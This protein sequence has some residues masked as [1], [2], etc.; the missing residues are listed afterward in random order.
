MLLTAHFGM[1]SRP[2]SGTNSPFHL[3]SNDT[4]A[5]EAMRDAEAK[6]QLAMLSDWDHLTSKEYFAAQVET[7]LD[8][9]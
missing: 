7:G 1:I 3:I 2:K 6:P 9:L 4:N 5:I 8:I